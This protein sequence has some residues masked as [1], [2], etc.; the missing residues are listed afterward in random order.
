MMA[1][2]PYK[3][4]NWVNLVIDGKVIK[5]LQICAVSGNEAWSSAADDATTLSGLKP[6]LITEK[7]LEAFGFNKLHGNLWSANA[8]SQHKP[9]SVEFGALPEDPLNLWIG[10]VKV[11]SFKH[12]YLHTLQNIA[13]DLCEIELKLNK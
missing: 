11:R 7:I 10:K 6:I 1:S 2:N 9:I 5:R 12:L 8:E 4:G 13:A 3:V